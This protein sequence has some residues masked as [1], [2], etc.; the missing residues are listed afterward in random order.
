MNENTDRLESHIHQ[1]YEFRSNIPSNLSIEKVKEVWAVEKKQSDIPLVIESRG[2]I[3]GEK[4][5]V[6]KESLEWLILKPFVKFVAISG[7]VGSEFAEE[8]DDI[9]LFIVVKNDTVWI[10]RLCVYIRNILKKGIRSK[11]SS[12]RNKEVK[13]KLCINFLAEQRGLLFDED[14]FNLNELLYMVPIYNRDF[15][16]VIFL[17]NSW[18]KDKYMVS[19][20][21]LDK[22]KLKVGDVKELTKRNYFIYPINFISFLGQL[23][24][25]IIMKHDPDLKRLWSGFKNGTVEFYPKNFKEEKIKGLRPC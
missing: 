9:D 16:S 18:L 17:N 6:A 13:D 24:F 19:D 20:K 14:I 4:L 1:L 5:E 21:F 10:Y 7:S 22:G 3:I 15:L 2:N 11:G 25:M 8:E 23:F 12:M